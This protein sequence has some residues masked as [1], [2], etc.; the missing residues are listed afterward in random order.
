MDGKLRGWQSSGDVPGAA[1]VPGPRSGRLLQICRLCEAGSRK[2]APPGLSFSHLSATQGPDG[3]EASAQLPCIHS[4]SR[5]TIPSETV[6]LLLT[7]G[8]A[9]LGCEQESPHLGHSVGPEELGAPGS[10]CVW[11]C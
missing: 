7:T 5:R 6:I 2:G 8:K 10:Q 1:G 4:S 3:E 11:E 9:T